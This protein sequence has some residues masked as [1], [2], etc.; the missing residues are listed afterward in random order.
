MKLNKYH[1]NIEVT[2][3]TCA[4]YVSKVRCYIGIITCVIVGH[5]LIYMPFLI[6]DLHN[7]QSWFLCI[8]IMGFIL[9]LYVAY[10]QFQKMQKKPNPIIFTKHMLI[11]PDGES[12]FWN[13]GVDIKFVQYPVGPVSCY[14][15]TKQRRHL[16]IDWGLY[17]NRKTL[18]F[19]FK[20]FSHKASQ[21]HPKKRS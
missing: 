16:L 6:P 18:E 4:I 1:Q 17:T 21:L 3:E 19:L 8:C 20:K 5:V 11:L 15:V 2:L 9:S 13:E 10:K 12:F 14:I 7:H